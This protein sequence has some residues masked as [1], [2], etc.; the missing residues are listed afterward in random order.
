[1]LKRILKIGMLASIMMCSFGAFAQEEQPA[2]KEY[3][4]PNYGLACQH[5][6][7]GV[8]NFGNTSC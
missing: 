6:G 3:Q 7:F 1:M 5:G 4:Y 8:L 2:Q